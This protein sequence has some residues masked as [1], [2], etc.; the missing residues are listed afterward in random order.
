MLTVGTAKQDKQQ[1][2]KTK[3]TSSRRFWQLL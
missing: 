3:G 2:Q 1:F